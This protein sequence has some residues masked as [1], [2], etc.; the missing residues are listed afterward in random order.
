MKSLVQS[1]SFM[2]ADLKVT[3]DNPIDKK[4]SYEQLNRI[5]RLIV[6]QRLFHYTASDICRYFLTPNC[7]RSQ[8]S[9]K[10]FSKKDFYLER[11][12]E[13]LDYD[14]GVVNIIR[15]MHNVDMMYA[16][17]FTEFE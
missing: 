9:V 1:K 16:T 4:P 15:A 5:Y 6:N 17:L 10:K 12:V 8:K 11:G 14:L 13:K 2:K 7:C 3:K